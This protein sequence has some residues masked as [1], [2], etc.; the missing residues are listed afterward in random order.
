MAGGHGAG[1]RLHGV[2]ALE[3]EL[4]GGAPGGLR[5]GRDEDDWLA[6]AAVG[7]QQGAEQGGLAG[8]GAAFQRRPP[9]RRTQVLERGKLLL[10]EPRAGQGSELGGAGEQLRAWGHHPGPRLGAGDLD[11]PL[12]LGE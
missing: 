6:V 4:A 1:E 10:G 7:A 8:A 3:V 12:L 5:R 11:D 9:D 2:A